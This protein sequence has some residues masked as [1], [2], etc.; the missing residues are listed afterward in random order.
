[1]WSGN[2]VQYNQVQGKSERGGVPWRAYALGGFVVLCPSPSDKGDFSEM[3]G[4]HRLEEMSLPRKARG[5]I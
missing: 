3:H 4:E 1:M 2:S 5:C